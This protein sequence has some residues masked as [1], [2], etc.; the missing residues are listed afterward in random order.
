MYT[1]QAQAKSNVLFRSF[2]FLITFI[3]LCG[4]VVPPQYV[5]A[6]AASQSV[7]D[8][9]EPGVMVPPAGGF[10]PCIIKG[11]T[12][13]SNNPLRFDFILDTGEE[14]FNDQEVREYSRK[15]VKYFLA[16]LTVSEKK[17]WV[18]LSP[19]ENNRIISDELGRTEMGRDMLAQDYILK[20][21]TSSMMYPED[22]LGAEFWYKVYARAQDR[23]GT[24]DIPLNTFNKIWIIP[25]KAEIFELGSRAFVV[26]SHL[27]VMLEEDFIALQ[28]NLGKEKFD[29]KNMGM[30]EAE[31]MS[32]ISAEVVREVLIPEIEREVNEGKNFAQLRQIYH[33]MIL[34]TW[35]KMRLKD[36]LLSRVY[37][38]KGK[39]KGVE[40]ADKEINTKIYDQYL[41]AFQKGVY[42]YIKEDYDPATQQLI[43]RKYFS[44][45]ETFEDLALLITADKTLGKFS[46]TETPNLAEVLSGLTPVQQEMIQRNLPAKGTHFDVTVDLAELGREAASPNRVDEAIV[47]AEQNI[48]PEMIDLDRAMLNQAEI[49]QRMA[50]IAQRVEVAAKATVETRVKM[51]LS[52]YSSRALNYFKSVFGQYLVSLDNKLPQVEQAILDENFFGTATAAERLGLEEVINIV[53]WI[54]NQDILEQEDELLAWARDNVIHVSNDMNAGKGTS[55]DRESM[56]PLWWGRT[57]IGAKAIDTGWIQTEVTGRDAAGREKTFLENI[58]VA[59]YRLV[60]FLRMARDL[61]I[62]QKEEVV[63]VDSVPWLDASLDDIYFF[64]RVDDRIAPENKRTYRQVIA[65]LESEG[66]RFV[67]YNTPSS[68]QESVPNILIETNELVSEINGTNVVTPGGHGQIWTDKLLESLDRDIAADKVT[69]RTIVNA[70]GMSNVFSPTQLAYI[71]KNKIPIAVMGSIRMPLDAKGGILGL[72]QMADGSYALDILELAAA[73]ESGK[74]EEFQAEGLTR[75][76]LGKQLFN[77]NN[78]AANVSILKPFLND[79]RE[80]LGDEAF[81]SLV[82]G[83]LMGNPK[84]KE[85]K[86]VIQM[87]TVMVMAVLKLHQYLEVNRKTNPAIDQLMQEHGIDRLV[88]VIVVGADQ[89]TDHFTPVKFSWDLMLYFFSDHFQLNVNMDDQSLAFTNLSEGHLPSFDMSK[90]Y[91]V[92]ENSFNALGRNVSMIGLDHLSMQGDLVEM[93]DVVLQRT[94]SIENL[95]GETQNLNQLLSGF[96]QVPTSADG[97][98]VL[99]NM[100]VLIN[101]SGETTVQ[102]DAAMLIDQTIGTAV[103]IFSEEVQANSLQIHGAL[104]RS[105]GQESLARFIRE[106]SGLTESELPQNQIQAM[107]NPLQGASLEM[108]SARSGVSLAELQTFIQDNMTY[109]AFEDSFTALLNQEMA[110][111]AVSD[112]VKNAWKVFAPVIAP[113]QLTITDISDAIQGNEMDLAMMTM[114]D[115]RVIKDFMA[116]NQEL[117]V[118]MDFQ[119]NVDLWNV[120]GLNQDDTQTEAFATFDDFLRVLEE[121]KD[122]LDA[123]NGLGLYFTDIGRGVVVDKNLYVEPMITLHNRGNVKL[124]YELARAISGATKNIA[125]ARVIDDIYAPSFDQAMLTDRERQ[126]MG[127]MFDE[128]KGQVVS[129]PTA[130]EQ[131]VVQLARMEDRTQVRWANLDEFSSNEKVRAGLVAGERVAIYFSGA[132]IGFL[133]STSNLANLINNIAQKDQNVAFQLATTLAN[134]TD[135]RSYQSIFRQTSIAKMLNIENPYQLSDTARKAFREILSGRAEL[136]LGGLSGIMGVIRQGVNGLRDM[137]VLV[138]DQTRDVLKPFSSSADAQSQPQIVREDTRAVSPDA[139]HLA[140][141]LALDGL[142]EWA[143]FS[144][145]GLAQMLYSMYQRPTNRYAADSIISGILEGLN[146]NFT[147]EELV[148]ATFD[149]INQNGLAEGR[150][151]FTQGNLKALTDSLVG[152]S[153]SISAENIQP[154]ANNM[155]GL[156]RFTLSGE[157]VSRMERLPMTEVGENEINVNFINTTTGLRNEV[158]VAK[159]N[160]VRMLALGFQEQPDRTEALMREMDQATTD[161]ASLTT[162]PVGGIDLN[163]A[164]LD[165]QIK[166][167]G[168]GFPLPLEQQPIDNMQI[169]GFLPVI[170]NVTPINSLPLLLGLSDEET[171]VFKAAMNTPRPIEPDTQPRPMDI[172]LLDNSWA[173]EPRK[174]S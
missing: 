172:S 91:K 141:G 34:A 129:I 112:M 35:Y 151:V 18:N 26:E 122:D 3:V 89:R 162:Q 76:M 130:I 43:P 78:V 136:E 110:S 2:S 68:L 25:E 33:S 128:Q 62:N 58:S 101:Q 171:D 55:V 64:D 15:L 149:V 75:G 7:L 93:Q 121:R 146:V 170:I 41:A 4:F 71:A 116:I 95:S 154:F 132:G 135:A 48:Q 174:E 84:T 42:N 46:L 16:A 140:W 137:N 57:E 119:G 8:L 65:D 107:T 59:E 131:Q 14:I 81:Y 38:N 155:S 165:L 20:Q 10:T 49:D 60:N 54:E 164:L 37:V 70:D 32:G 53:G 159:E 115:I 66:V 77:T 21:L 111:A 150:E 139:I 124:S 79:L 160:F 105:V 22:N 163:P 98:M 109:N 9:P 142:N 86:D 158:I 145:E 36:S 28:N 118:L 73:L 23:Y 114:D 100:A 31:V 143:T 108:I 24:T 102:F 72:R 103:R 74:G 169:E 153:V 87:E 97:H 144:P 88:N 83:N 39:T 126:V 99:G 120:L 51:G 69:I 61:Y 168:N 104:W 148:D 45:G 123:I 52:P 1:Y 30:N 50:V 29:T 156:D 47:L 166:R 63:S 94:V 173:T 117:G 17:M 40:N 13:H 5:Y 152:S 167:D 67:D 82:T 133:A 85:G 90:V 19:Y 125:I 80:L 157:I 96:E 106:A 147:T 56:L 92:T 161:A 138:S 11:I 127:Q 12:I 6:Q 27:K 113:D 44:G 134:A